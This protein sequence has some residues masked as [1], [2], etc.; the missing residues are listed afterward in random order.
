MI[1]QLSTKHLLLAGVFV[2]RDG[3]ERLGLRCLGLVLVHRRNLPVAV[4]VRTV[5]VRSLRLDD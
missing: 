5:T 2:L 1:E 4:A 3:V